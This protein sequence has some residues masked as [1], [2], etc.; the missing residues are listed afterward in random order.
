MREH[1]QSLIEFTIFLPIF[2]V[3]I[4]ALA[5]LGFWFVER[6]QV[7]DATREGAR[8]GTDGDPENYKEEINAHSPLYTMDIK[9]DCDTETDFYAVIACYSE[10]LLSY[11]GIDLEND[12]G[13]DDVV[14][15]AYTI[16]NGRAKYYF[17]ED[18]PSGWSWTGNQV[19]KY[20]VTLIDESVEDDVPISGI[21]IV[22]VYKLH[23]QKFCIPIFSAFVPCDIPMYAYSI[24]PNST[25][26]SLGY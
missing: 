22:E 25:A 6:M 9:I 15:S 16:V 13:F 14:V 7:L 5:N 17:P 1:G 19:S 8:Y 26:A 12:N 2:I 23:H 24:F 3:L 21:V 11:G 20:D 4:A 10:S 18:T